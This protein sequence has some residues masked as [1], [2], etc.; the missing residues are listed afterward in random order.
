MDVKLGL[1]VMKQLIRGQVAV[2]CHSGRL[3]WLQHK[4]KFESKQCL[5]NAKHRQGRAFLLVS[6][7]RDLEPFTRAAGGL[8]VALRAFEGR[9]LDRACCSKM[10]PRQAIRVGH[11]R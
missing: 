5:R 9:L 1:R 4:S 8:A 3:A 6:R 7:L 11:C 2:G 10:S